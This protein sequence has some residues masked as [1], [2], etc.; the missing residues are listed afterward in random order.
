MQKKFIIFLVIAAISMIAFLFM[1]LLDVFGAEASMMDLLTDAGIDAILDM[2]G[3]FLLLIALVAGIAGIVG[4]A[5]Q[6][7]GLAS[8]ISL[9]AVC[10]LIFMVLYYMELAK[11][12]AEFGDVLDI[13]GMGFWVS[14]I[15][16]VAAGSFA[17]SKNA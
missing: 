15:T 1:P 13:F 9:G 5:L 7:K 6:N 12:G 4:G 16:F 2:K 8:V 10:E 17:N 14:M 11:W 3:G